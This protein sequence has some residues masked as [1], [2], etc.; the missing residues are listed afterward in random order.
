MIFLTFDSFWWSDFSLVS[1]IDYFNPQSALDLNNCNRA[2]KVTHTTSS[3]DLFL[4][5]VMVDLRVFAPLNLPTFYRPKCMFE[6]HLTVCVRNVTLRRYPE[7]LSSLVL[8]Q[9]SPDLS[10]VWYATADCRHVS[11]RRLRFVLIAATSKFDIVRVVFD[12]VRM[13]FLCECFAKCS[14]S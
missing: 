10:Y 6:Y 5:A 12:G 9:G 8:L 13:V 7:S 14:N 4:S 11:S 1:E 3:I 2:G